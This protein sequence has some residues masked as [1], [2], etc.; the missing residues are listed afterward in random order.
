MKS[1]NLLTFSEALEALK[2]GKIVKRVTWKDKTQFIY[3]NKGSLPADE[4]F[5]GDFEGIMFNLFQTGDN[6]TVP[7]LP[8]INMKTSTA[9]LT[10]WTASQTDILSEDWVVHQEYTKDSRVFNS[11]ALDIADEVNENYTAIDIGTIYD[12]DESLNDMYDEGSREE[13]IESFTNGFNY[14]E[15]QIVEISLTSV[16]RVPAIV[17]K[18]NDRDE[19]G[20]LSYDIV[21]LIGE[22]NKSALNGEKRY[23]W[24]FTEKPNSKTKDNISNVLK[25][26][27]NPSLGYNEHFISDY[28]I[29]ALCYI[30]ETGMMII[31][32]LLE[33]FKR[34]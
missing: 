6:G 33:N 1:K 30:D 14:L 4:T 13:T 17:T 31:Y 22:R 12:L 32:D 28:G 16:G 2:D 21:V 29:E 10:G 5:A 11:L 34:K 20:H 9:T 19:N 23:L 24:R 3:L 18:V 15:G 8:N 26:L 25:T 27:F 7:R